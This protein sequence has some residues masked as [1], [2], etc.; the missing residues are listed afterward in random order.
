[1]KI[2]LV[3]NFPSYSGTGKVIYRSFEHLRKLKGITAD[4]YLTHFLKESDRRLP[5]N[6]GVKVLQPFNYD[7]APFLSRFFLYFVDPYLLPKGYDLYHFGNHMI[8]RFS[9]IRRPAVVTVHDVLQFTYPETQFGQGLTGKVYNHFMEESVRSLSAADRLICVSEWSRN[10]VLKFF[11][12]L[13]PEKIGVVY[14]G[15]DHGLFYPRLREEARSY[16]NLPKD[17]KILL[18]LGSEIER[19]Q[20]PLILKTFKAL[21]SEFPDLLLL[22][23][24][25]KK[26]KTSELISRL[27]LEDEIIYRHYSDESELPLIYSACDLL[28]QPSSDEGF[29]FPVIEAMACGLPV[30]A[31][32]RAS[33]PEIGGGAEAGVG[34]NLDEDSLSLAVRRGP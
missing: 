18:H 27:G 8:A 16:L 1:M 19:K 26:T 31:S 12:R 2:A 25:E 15:L 23:H 7:R 34:E 22:R 13:D 21:K 11:P 5:E 20:V 24:G 6:L 4:F 14:N 30:V 28:L 32:N 3:T 29:C 33:L 17:R 9:K 10:E